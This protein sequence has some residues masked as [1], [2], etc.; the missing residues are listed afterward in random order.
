LTDEFDKLLAFEASAGSGKTFSLVIRYLS[1]LILGSAPKSILALTFTKKAAFE[2]SHRIIHTLQNLHQKPSELSYLS[3]HLGLTQQELLARVA[4]INETLDPNELK[5]STIDSFFT[6]IL[7]LFSFY[8]DIAVDF[9]VTSSKELHIIEEQYLQKLQNEGVSDDFLEFAFIF[10]KSQKVIF[11]LLDALYQNGSF[12]LPQKEAPKVSTKQILQKLHQIKILMQEKLSPRALKQFEVASIDELKEKTFMAKESLN[13]WDFKKGFMPQVDILFGELKQ[14]MAYYY[15]N[16]EHYLLQKFTNLFAKYQQIRQ[17]NIQ[18]SAELTFGEVS[19]LTKELLSGMDSDFLYFRLDG[20]I[21]HILIDEF[22]DTNTLQF[23]ILRPLIDEITSGEN[24]KEFQ[25]F[26]YVGDKKQSIYRFRGGNKELFDIVANRYEVDVKKLSVNYRSAHNIVEFVNDTFTSVI[27]G[28]HPQKAHIKEKG[29]VEV[30]FDEDV[31]ENIYN[32]LEDLLQSGV[33][34]S[35]IAILT[36]VN[37]DAKNIIEYLLMREPSLVVHNEAKLLLRDIPMVRAIVELMF[38]LVFGDAIYKAGFLHLTSQDIDTPVPKEEFDL[39]LS[40]YI[41]A[42]QIITKYDL[43]DGDI[44]LFIFLEA[45]HAYESIE[46]FVLQYDHFDTEAIL[47]KLQGVRVLTIHK[48]KGL[49]FHSVIIADKLKGKNNSSDLL[50]LEQEGLNPSTMHLRTSKREHFDPSYACVIDNEKNLADEDDLNALYV[51]FTRARSN[52]IICHKEQKS[53]FGSLKLEKKTIGTIDSS[54][55]TDSITE[56]TKKMLPSEVSYGL[57]EYTK[58]PKSTIEDKSAADFGTAMHYML[59]MCGN[60]C[61]KDVDEAY[62]AM[63]SMMAH[64]LTKSQLEEIQSRII[65]LIQKEIFCDIAQGKL[66]KEFSLIIDGEL[67][68]IDLLSEFEDKFVIVDYKSSIVNQHKHIEQI[69]MYQKGVEQLSKK[70]VECYLIY[71]LE[72]ECLV[73]SEN[74]SS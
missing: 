2:M 14:M 54:S 10:D 12:S 64:K 5:I 48:S 69:G 52:L 58:K 29:F 25:S 65:K 68:V 57:Q 62:M 61:Q 41:L 1:L 35:D 42:Y 32:S 33:S 34:A 74:G 50:I 40:P 47:K 21:D 24:A 3:T 73:V 36:F 70:S 8:A 53:G 46:Q 31:Y 38:Y 6:S 39:S 45:L 30:R 67:R 17:Q 72:D 13:Y 20:A 15:Q 56:D 37:D 7:R 11:A 43:F 28:Y 51:A 49:E 19:L 4:K 44:N 26:F 66:Y 55:Q 23:Q 71:L 27:D 22:Q 59:Q 9:R 63:C 16:K 60:F 18:K